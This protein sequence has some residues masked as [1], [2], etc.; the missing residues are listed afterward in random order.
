M[1]VNGKILWD[2]ME[3]GECTVVNTS[4]KC[5]GTIT[6]SRTKAN[7]LEESILD[8]V[9]VNPIIAPYVTGMEIDESKSNM[10]SNSKL[11]N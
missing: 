8:Y 4:E 5:K 6:R 1:S 7:K 2:I 9:I 3:R 11:D 10:W